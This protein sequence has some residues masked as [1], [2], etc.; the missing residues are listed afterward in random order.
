MR[1]LLLHDEGSSV[2]GGRGAPLLVYS[3]SVGLSA[4]TGTGRS[5]GATDCTSA[6][7]ATVSALTA[8]TVASGNSD[9]DGDT[10]NNGSGAGDDDDE[11]ESGGGSGS[12]SGSGSRRRI[13]RSS[14]Q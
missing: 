10:Y 5:V 7:P 4:G 6:R 8:P 1:D 9:G 14:V 3:L 12:E 11:L 2:E 13:G